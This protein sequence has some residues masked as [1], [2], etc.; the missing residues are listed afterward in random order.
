M[1]NI[2]PSVLKQM[3]SADSPSPGPIVCKIPLFSLFSLVIV[4]VLLVA[5]A[6]V[7][8]IVYVLL[9][10]LLSLLLLLLLMIMNKL[11]FKVGFTIFMHSHVRY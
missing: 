8:V 4:A 2:P 11:F 3:A 9:L 1:G 5:I 6:V 7:V 10:F